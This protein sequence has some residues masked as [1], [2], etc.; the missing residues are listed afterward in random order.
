MCGVQTWPSVGGVQLCADLRTV[1]GSI[2]FSLVVG[3]VSWASRVLISWIIQ[4]WTAVPF[5]DCARHPS[6]PAHCM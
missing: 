3:L 2:D 1:K 5:P 6:L 4:Q